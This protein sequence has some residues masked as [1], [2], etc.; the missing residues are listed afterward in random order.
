MVPTKKTAPDP[1]Y[2]LSPALL[3]LLLLILLCAKL[4]VDTLSFLYVKSFAP[5]NLSRQYKGLND[6]TRFVG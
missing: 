2:L 1:L 5:P 3:I 6:Y 4:H